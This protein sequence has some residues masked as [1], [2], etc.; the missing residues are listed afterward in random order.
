M[1]NDVA[2]TWGRLWALYYYLERTASPVWL[3]FFQ[4]APWHVLRFGHWSV[5]P[6]QGS[7]SVDCA[8]EAVIGRGF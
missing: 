2:D 6:R 1:A 5:Q 4:G 7:S 8:V 3:D